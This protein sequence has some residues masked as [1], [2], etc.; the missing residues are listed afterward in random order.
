MAEIEVTDT[1]IPAL[2]SK[3]ST[4]EWLTPEFQR[5]F[6]WNTSAV[7]GLINSIIDAKPIGMVT[8]WEQENKS[9]LELEH[10]SVPDWDT[11]KNVTGPRYYGNNE[12]R[13]GR[14]YAILD[15]KQRSTAIALAFGG[16]RAKSGNYKHSGRYFLNVAAADPL[17]R[18]EHIK[19]LDVK[20][21]G[22]DT[23]ATCVGQGLFPL[24]AT[25]PGKIFQQWMGYTAMIGNA[26]NY[27]GGQLPSSEELSMRNDLLQTAFDGI[28]STKLAVYVVPKDENLASIC[29][30]FETLNTTGTKVSTVDLIH[31]WLYADTKERLSSPIL[32]RQE[33]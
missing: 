3:L 23:L 15:G 32:L 26:E 12:K 8:L 10:I 4:G 16:L 2:L 19:E 6:V 24:E 22:L 13:P 1:T 5:E 17:D 20:A 21:R 30:I 7:I 28:I 29:E 14:Y 9:D 18:I 27:P 31:S 11:A 25:E 33:L